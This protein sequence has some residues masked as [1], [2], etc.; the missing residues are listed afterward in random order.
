MWWL[1][2][3]TLAAPVL[4]VDRSKFRRC[5]D[6]N[7]CYRNRYLAQHHVHS[8]DSGLRYDIDFQIDPGTVTI[9]GHEVHFEVKSVFEGENPFLGVLKVFEGGVLHFVLKEKEAM[10]PRYA[11][12]EGEVI[13]FSQL[14]PVRDLKQAVKSELSLDY[15]SGNTRVLLSFVPVKLETFYKDQAVLMVNDRS[16]FNFERFRREGDHLPSASSE[17][18]APDVV[19]IIDAT[20][21]RDDVGSPK[22]QE[23]QWHET[24]GGHAD[25]KKKGPSSVAID[26]TFAGATHVYG[27]PEHADS[28]ALRDTVGLEPYRLF[29]GDVFEYELNERMA[30]YGAIPFMVSRTKGASGGFFW[31]NPSE[32]YIDIDTFPGGKRTHWMSETGVME[33]MTF[34]RSDALSVIQ[35]YTLTTGPAQL[36]PLFSLGFHQCRWNYNDQSDVLSVNSGFDTYDIPMDVIWLDIEHTDDKKYFTWDMNKFPN[37]TEMLATLGKSKRKLVTIVDP[38]MK[39]TESYGLYVEMERQG[40]LVKRESGE[41]YDGHCWPGNAVWPDYTREEVRQFWAQQFAHTAYPHS[42]SNLFTWND[43]NEPAVFNSPE[44]TMPRGNLHGIYEHRDVHNLYGYYM[45]KSTFEGHL[46][47]GPERPFVLTRS[48]FAGSQKWGAAWTGDN[49]AKWEYMDFSIPMMLSMATAGFSFI[50]SDVGGFFGDPSKELLVRWHQVGAYTPFFRAHAHIETKRREPWLMGEPATTRIRNAIRERYQ[51]LP[52]W[53]TLFYQYHSEGTPVVRPLFLQFPTDDQSAAMDRSYMV[54]SALLVAPPL[55]QTDT[56]S[57]EI[58]LPPSR[59]FDYHTWLEVPSGR[60]TVPVTEDYIPVYI[61]GGSIIPRQDRARR[62]ST[63][64]SIDPYTLIV[65]LD[66]SLEAVGHIY[67]DDWVT[68]GTN[69]L[70]SV[71]SFTDNTLTYRMIHQWQKPNTV[72]R[73]VILGLQITPKRV[74]VSGEN[75]DYEVGFY[76]YTNGAVVVKLPSVYLSMDWTLKLKY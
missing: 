27:I 56:H 2:F 25:N 41:V 21:V 72:E 43:M 66:S 19:P 30:L 16:L 63:L 37:P 65:A 68:N 73:I 69:Y 64:M 74:V 50:G 24:F 40:Y 7:F 71:L 60:F 33:F 13:N 44:L 18:T 14:K 4:S 38:H 10:H 62:S 23:G 35:S 42:A 67:S 48:F 17:E 49:A 52:Y 31:V 9:S 29:N 34:T 46:K 53:Y 11:I 12:P 28:L 20:Q 61:R 47:R 8:Q 6:S 76:D 3:L 45:H 54:G 26:V 15:V 1:I 57:L 75:E 22:Y 36:P 55:R 5:E 32:T 70:Y 59:W 51:L 58:Y 39:K